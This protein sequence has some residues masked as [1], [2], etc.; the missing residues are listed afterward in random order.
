[1]LIEKQ[2]TNTIKK[3]FSTKVKEENFISK[4]QVEKTID[5][6]Y[7]DLTTNCALTLSKFLKKNP[8]LVA[9]ELK[10]FLERDFDGKQKLFKIKVKKPGF[11]NFFLSSVAYSQNLFFLL[12]CKKEELVT[13]TKTPRKILLEYVS[14]NP[15]GDLHMGHGRGAVIGSSLVQILKILGNQV[16]TEYY[17]NDAGEQINKLG[18]SAW[19]IYQNKNLQDLEYPKELLDF[20]I[21]QIKEENLELNQAEL[22]E[23]LKNK[24]IKS[25]K[26]ILEKLNV[27]FTNWI[28]EKETIHNSGLLDKTLKVFEEKKLLYQKDQALWLK[29]SDFGDERDRVL[30]KSENKK[31]TYLLGDLAYHVLKFEKAD[32]LIDIFGSDHQGQEKSLKLSLEKLNTSGDSKKKLKIMFVQFVS[33]KENN[34]EFK[35]SKRAGK[36]ISV[37]E[38]TEKIGTDAFRFL[39]L[40]SSHNNRLILDID[41]AKQEDDQNPV[42]YV[43]YSHARAYSILKNAL[44]K[45]LFD[46]EAL[47]TEEDLSNFLKRQENLEI[48]LKTEKL[49]S[50]EVE[51]TK[52]L[53]TELSNFEK[54][55]YS[56]AE[57]LNPSGITHYL[58]SL[59][60]LFHSFYSVCRVIDYEKKD[61]SL[62]RLLLVKAYVRVLSEA[63]S[64]ILVSAPK[65]MYRAEV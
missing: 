59:A 43:Q 17:I 33:L 51:S 5:P 44:E 50:K 45:N 14:A 2:L 58:I 57:N 19:N 31:A 56:S 46:Q 22:T 38:V 29:S 26:E 40:L 8:I 15:T 35:M 55:V 12:T 37:R 54:T 60:N 20:Y 62:A 3:F 53:I 11:V 36:L 13:K 49:N 61:L 27:E 21:N 9:E 23:I 28:S 41:L 10:A 63:L 6:Q 42:F 65:K 48:L 1:M 7:G 4:I 25:Q 39:L 32:L 34:Q 24:I 64:L 52:N 30:I 18:Q 47:C 16:C